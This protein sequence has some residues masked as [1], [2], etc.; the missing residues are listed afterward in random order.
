[1]FNIFAIILIVILFLIDSEKTIKGIKSGIKKI[2]KNLPIFLNMIIFIVISLYFISD[3]MILK[4]LASGRDVKNFSIAIAIGSIIFMPGFIVFPLA[5]LLISKGVG[6]GTIA[7]FTTSLMLV[8]I[9]TIQIEIEYFGKKFA[10]IRNLT[11]IVL[12][13]IVSIFIGLYFGVV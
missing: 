12:S 5:G 9:A 8:G 3:E 11:G 13:I 1:M 4:I 6:Y 10:I 7:A 2:K